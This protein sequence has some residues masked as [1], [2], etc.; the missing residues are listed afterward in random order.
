VVGQ[1][2][3][4][5]ST[6]ITGSAQITDDADVSSAGAPD[7]ASGGPITL[8]A[9]TTILGALGVANDFY[10]V[11]SGND[12]TVN[13]GTAASGVSVNL[14]GTEPP[15]D[16]SVTQQQPGLVL[17]NGRGSG[18]DPTKGAGQNVAAVL[19]NP[20]GQEVFEAVESQIIETL[21]DPSQQIEEELRL[22]EEDVAPGE[23]DADKEK[24]EEEKRRRSKQK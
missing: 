11:S 20:A 8:V 5:G 21:G 23:T 3:S 24:E 2:V 7:L 18:I 4:G 12:I 13:A 1:V 15:V 10:I 14:W 6:A 16:L 19:A 9:G 22:E 17:W